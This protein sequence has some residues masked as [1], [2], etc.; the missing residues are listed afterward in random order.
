M[1]KLCAIFVSIF[2]LIPA[3]GFCASAGELGINYQIR[4]TNPIVVGPIKQILQ[5]NYPKSP[6]LEAE[7]EIAIEEGSF[8]AP[9]ENSAFSAF[10]SVFRKDLD[11]AV[12]VVADHNDFFSMLH[13][14]GARVTYQIRPLVHVPLD[15]AKSVNNKNQRQRKKTR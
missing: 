15:D 7:E 4:Y 3:T 9:Q 5:G 8:V 2:C 10:G 12:I 11:E 6:I 13:V 14:E 1:F